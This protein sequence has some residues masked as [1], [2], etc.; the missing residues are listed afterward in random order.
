M[1]GTQRTLRTKIA[2]AGVIE[3][4]PSGGWGGRSAPIL[5][6]TLPALSDPSEK[7]WP[8]MAKA[9][10]WRALCADSVS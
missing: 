1:G 4:Q 7:L 3:S 2:D 6:P 10:S 5:P 8:E 9:R